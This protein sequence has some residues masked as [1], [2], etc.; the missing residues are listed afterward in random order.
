[1]SP[2][3][4]YPW[5]SPEAWLTDPRMNHAWLIH[6]QKGIGKFQFALAGSASLLCESP[7]NGL[8]CGHCQSCHLF[9]SW[10][11]P[12][13]RLLISDMEAS[14]RGLLTHLIDDPQKATSKQIL[15][16]KVRE[17]DDFL[18]ISS[19]RGGRRVVMIYLA[20]DLNIAS[21]NAL[22]KSIEE[23]Y[24]EV[25]FLLVSHSMGRVL[26]TIISR[27]RRL[28]LPIPPESQSIAWLTQQ[29]IEHPQDYLAAGSGAP[30]QAA[31]YAS[32]E[33]EPIA[34]WLKDF[35][36]HLCLPQFPSLSSYVEKL[37]N[38]TISEWLASLY[39]FLLDIALV[40]RTGHSHYYPSLQSYYQTIA[41][42][43]NCLVISQLQKWL[44][45]QIAL[46]NLNINLNP[47]NFALTVLQKVVQNLKK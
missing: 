16:G 36:H 32:S 39:R 23:P 28:F 3:E 13:F 18:S 46:N 40:Q 8:A 31:S 38:I 29:G 15:I 44:N 4:F 35:A 33:N 43:T 6:G 19:H 34:Y 21:S 41:Q 47:K 9:A 25:V 26:P 45:E 20:E 22:L 27:C 5:Q 7:K 17:L 10:N 11:H 42:Q 24:G 30:L 1:M 12:D 37:E 14:E 2:F